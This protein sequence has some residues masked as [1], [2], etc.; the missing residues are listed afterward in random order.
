MGE[1]ER[2]SSRLSG[3]YQKSIAERREILA[4]WADL[5]AEELAALDEGLS[6]A[7]ADKMIENVVGRYSLPLA[8]A[9]NFLING[10]E[11]L[12]PMVIEE[13]SVV[14]AVSYAA[15]LARTGGGFFTGSTAPIMIGQIQLLDAP[16]ME[17]AAAAIHAARAELLRHADTSP[18]IRKLG[19]GPKD[20]Q[21]RALAETPAGPMLVVHLLF[22]CRDAMG[23]NAVNTAAEALAPHLE[24]LT[25]GRALLRILSNY[26]DQRRAWAEVRIPAASFSTADFAGEDVVRGI[27]EANALA[28]VDPYRA[29]THNKGIFN[30]IDA[31]LMATGNDWRAVEAGGHAYAA[32]DGQYRAL[33]E[34]RVE[35]E[36][37]EIGDW[38]T[39]GEGASAKSKDTNTPDL[40]ISQSPDLPISLYGR[41]EMPL[42]VG[43]VGGATRSHPTAQAALK[44]LGVQSARELAE[45]IV[46]VGLAQNL[47]ALRALATHGIQRGHMRMHARQVAI[48]AGAAPEQV[49]AVA[50]RLIQEG[51]IRL[52]RARAIVGEMG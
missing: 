35:K 37:L 19:G 16:D 49:D 51:E 28:V 12:V 1:R 3:Y 14:A 42:S 8:I 39:R 32:R 40:P 10:R 30:G 31:V 6:L 38:R 22:D 41:L 18:T 25:G 15:R 46:A 4:R 2:P 13:P 21:V 26:T 11:V 36:R 27:A 44:I 45:I 33:T 23:A 20:I 34:W 17:R 9:P 24:A 43:I 47:A 52:E 29:A 48:A 50:A 7:Q 5:S